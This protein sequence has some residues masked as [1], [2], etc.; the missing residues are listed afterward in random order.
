MSKVTTIALIFLA[1]LVVVGSS[2]AQDSGVHATIPFDFTVGAKLLPAGTYTITSETTLA[3]AV[4]IESNKQHVDIFSM[5]YA[6]DN[7]SK[8]AVL[9]FHKHGKQYFLSEI[10]KSSTDM[11]LKIPTSN[12]EKRARLQE[13]ADLHGNVD[14]PPA[15]NEVLVALK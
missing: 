2:S 4:R 3:H 5:A 12:M 7:P 13:R 14:L 11:N 15:S 6:T 1:S 9:V 8:K 10:L